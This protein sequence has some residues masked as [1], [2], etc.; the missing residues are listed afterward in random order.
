MYTEDDIRRLTWQSRR[1]MLELDLLFVPFM[2]E[3]FRGLPQEDQDRF[4]KL[5]EC[6]D[7]DLFVW[8]MEREAPSDPDMNRIVRII[9]DRV[10]PS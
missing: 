5:L 3:A 8:L 2:E 7:Q 6:E 9:L 4:V 10:Q 1:G